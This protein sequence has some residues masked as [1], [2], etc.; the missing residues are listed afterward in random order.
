MS[1]VI[2][3]Y[4]RLLSRGSDRGVWFWRKEARECGKNQVRQRWLGPVVC[5]SEEGRG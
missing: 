3:S 1:S 2:G 5:P 4:G